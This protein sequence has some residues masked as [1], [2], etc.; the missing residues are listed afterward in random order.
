MY[1]NFLPISAMQAYNVMM[2]RVR[3]FV[4]DG[5]ALEWILPRAGLPSLK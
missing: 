5:S 1:K 3:I 4:W 2:C